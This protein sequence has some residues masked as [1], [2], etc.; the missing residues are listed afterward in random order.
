MSTSANWELKSWPQFFNEII[1]GHKTHDL[2]RSTD[3]AFKVGDT[4]TLREYDQKQE[5]YTGREAKVL[6]TY[7]TNKISPCAYSDE[8]LKEGFCILSIKLLD[9]DSPWK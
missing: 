4:L 3:R 7:V 5:V 6:V 8:A 2:R 1:A 9:K